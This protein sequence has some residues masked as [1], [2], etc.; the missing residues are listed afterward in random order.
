MFFF[1]GNSK[2]ETVIRMKK[3]IKSKSK[4]IVVADEINHWPKIDVKLGKT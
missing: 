2:S 4:A 1:T 3:D